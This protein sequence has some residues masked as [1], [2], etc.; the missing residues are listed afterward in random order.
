MEALTQ[1]RCPAGLPAEWLSPCPTHPG[2]EVSEKRK[3][4]DSGLSLLD[5]FPL[6]FDSVLGRKFCF[7][8]WSFFWKMAAGRRD[9]DVSLLQAACAPHGGNRKP[10]GWKGL[11]GVGEPPRFPGR[12]CPFSREQLWLPHDPHGWWCAPGYYRGPPCP[13]Y[14]NSLMVAWGLAV[15]TGS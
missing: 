9:G 15:G 1:S 2:L 8:N 7:T 11:A 6:S 4:C 5:F 12:G 10:Q 13:V 14:L 3:Y